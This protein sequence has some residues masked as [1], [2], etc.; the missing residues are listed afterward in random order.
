MYFFAV[1]RPSGD[2]TTAHQHFV[3]Y[4]ESR[5]E[6]LSKTTELLPF[7]ALHYMPRPQ[8]HKAIEHIFR[9]KWTIDLR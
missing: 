5:G 3:A 4:L 6:E 2:N 1:K 9:K 8:E 7:F